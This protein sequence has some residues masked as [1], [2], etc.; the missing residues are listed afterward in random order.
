MTDQEIKTGITSLTALVF[1][2]VGTTGVLLYFHLIETQIKALHEI[3]GL[4]FVGVAGLH[5]YSHWKPMQRYM[6]NRQFSVYLLLLGIISLFFIASAGSGENP[7]KKII[8]AVLD[9]PLEVSL[10]LLKSDRERFESKLKA[11]GITIN[12]AESI[13]DIAK[14]NRRSPFELVN[15]ITE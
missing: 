11:M 7:K 13:S 12:N 4:F 2:V 15:A 3:L 1:M 5:L 10:P 8:I 6:R 9:A 14:Q